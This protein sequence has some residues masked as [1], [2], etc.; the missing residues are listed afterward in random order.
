MTLTI[1]NTNILNSQ[2]GRDGGVFFINNKQLTKLDL[3]SVTVN[4]AKALNGNGGVIN[5]QAFNGPLTITSSYF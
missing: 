2:S 4:G 5:A 1:T 3:I